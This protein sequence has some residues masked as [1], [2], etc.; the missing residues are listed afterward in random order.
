MP[1]NK[2]G[3]RILHHMQKE[4]GSKKGKSVFYASRNKGT[5]AGVDPESL[6]GRLQSSRGRPKKRRVGGMRYSRA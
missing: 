4:Y 6:Q 3:T 5:I 1:L 2:K